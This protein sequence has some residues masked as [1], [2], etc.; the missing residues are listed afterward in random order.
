MLL[1]CYL[2]HFLQFCSSQ[3][4]KLTRFDQGPHDAALERR[5]MSVIARF[6]APS[7]ERPE[8]IANERQASE[9]QAMSAP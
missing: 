4:S 8:M 3:R 2:L 1:L 6:L 9:R 5:A 7:N